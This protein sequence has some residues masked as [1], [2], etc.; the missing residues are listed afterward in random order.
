MTQ[1]YLRGGGFKIKRPPP[2]APKLKGEKKPKA[3]LPLPDWSRVK[4]AVLQPSR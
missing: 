2:P 1:K 3:S 4:K